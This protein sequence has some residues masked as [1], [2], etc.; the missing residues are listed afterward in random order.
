M[1][2]NHQTTCCFLL[3][4]LLLRGG[5]A[6]ADLM[7]TLKPLLIHLPGWETEDVEVLDVKKG[8]IRTTALQRTYYKGEAEMTALL[9]ATSRITIDRKI[10]DLRAECKGDKVSDVKLDGFQAHLFYNAADNV[11][12][13]VVIL[14][15]GPSRAAML[16]LNFAGIDDKQAL[17]LVKKFD[18]KKMQA[19]TV[20]L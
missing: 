3:A 16:S 4:I 6:H 10:E 12:V 15:Q 17:F 14:N 18:W 9:M 1:R 8:V 19:E 7:D 20:K 13:V 2:T 5:A 11:G